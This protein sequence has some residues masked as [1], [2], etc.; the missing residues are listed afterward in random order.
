VNAIL[1]KTA[2]LPMLAVE[3]KHRS[4]QIRGREECGMER[5]AE[6]SLREEAVLMHELPDRDRRGS[7]RSW[8]KPP[9]LRT[10]L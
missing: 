3:P 8:R 9:G 10:G 2:A 7:F 4:E 5:G 1:R 6:N